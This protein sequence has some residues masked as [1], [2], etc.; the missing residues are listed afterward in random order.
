MNSD[1]LGWGLGGSLQSPILPPFSWSETNP[2]PGAS[3]NIPA[4]RKMQMSAGPFDLAS[5]QE[6]VMEF[7]FIYSRANTGGALA[8]LQK[9]LQTDAPRIRQWYN[10]T[11]FPSC[12]DLSTVS[13]NEASSQLKLRVYP[14]PA[15]SQ[16][17][18]ET[19]NEV[20]L[21][22]RITDMQGRLV[23]VAQFTAQTRYHL[24]LTE[25]SPGLYLLHWEQAGL[26]KTEK[27]VKQ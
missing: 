6:Q 18:V 15:S 5:G 23:Q 7:A 17:I 24:D 13:V 8:S 19:E 20:P 2:G 4:D 10:Q 3:P 16:L 11:Q 26:M 9:L 12:L 14:N 21:K 22:L 27:L 25:V 1:S